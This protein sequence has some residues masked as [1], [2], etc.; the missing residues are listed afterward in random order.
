MTS[1]FPYDVVELRLLDGIKLPDPFRNVRTEQ[2]L[3]HRPDGAPLDVEWLSDGI[4][5]CDTFIPHG[6]FVATL[7]E[8]PAPKAAPAK[9]PTRSRK[10]RKPSA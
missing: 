9:A 2:S 7:R 3:H 4:V 6:R 8:K 1:P 5:Y 10:R